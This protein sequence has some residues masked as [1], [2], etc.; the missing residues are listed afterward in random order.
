MENEEKAEQTHPKYENVAM[1][2]LAVQLERNLVSTWSA[3][4]G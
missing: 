1:K 3:Q 2:E 4:P